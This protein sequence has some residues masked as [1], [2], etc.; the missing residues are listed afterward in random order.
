MGTGSPCRLPTQQ[1]PTHL[2]KIRLMQIVHPELT[3]NRANRVTAA[4]SRT[5]RSPRPPKGTG[6]RTQ[7]V[8]EALDLSSSR[9]R[10]AVNHQ[11]VARDERREVAAKEQSD[12]SNV[13]RLATDSQGV[14]RDGLVDLKS[15]SA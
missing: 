11:N 1:N 5:M 12:T 13:I 4:M 8:H 14:R 7:R 10:P 6:V 3:P 15:T 2:N 9:R